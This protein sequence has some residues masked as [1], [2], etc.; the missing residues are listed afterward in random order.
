[1]SFN[2]CIDIIVILENALLIIA[3]KQIIEKKISFMCY[4]RQGA[5]V[6]LC[7]QFH[8]AQVFFINDMSS[9]MNHV[10]FGTVIGLP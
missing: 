4:R 6:P 5:N 2:Y 3:L 7:H 9:L 8:A 1:M 10:G